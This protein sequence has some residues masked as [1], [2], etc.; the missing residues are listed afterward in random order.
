MGNIVNVRL[1]VPGENADAGFVG[2]YDM[3]IM[4]AITIGGKSLN[5]PVFSYRTLDGGRLD[6][7]DG[8]KSSTVYCYYSDGSGLND[9]Y[10][11]CD[12]YKWTTI[13]SANDLTNFIARLTETIANAESNLDGRGWKCKLKEGSP[14]QRYLLNYYNCFHAVAV[15]MKWLGETRFSIIH[16]MEHDNAAAKYSATKM[17]NKFSGASNWV[18][19]L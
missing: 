13:A 14:F 3:Q 8:D 16:K 1:I 17:M 6:I 15:W 2:H 19:I 18:S 4:G 9:T 7:F 11:R 10:A 5:N 12:V